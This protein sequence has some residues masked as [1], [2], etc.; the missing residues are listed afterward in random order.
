[1]IDYPVGD[2]YI[3]VEETQE[4]SYNV[5]FENWLAAAVS[6]ETPIQHETLEI[7]VVRGNGSAPDEVYIYDTITKQNYYMLVEDETTESI[8]IPHNLMF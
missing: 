7:L 6:M 8:C 2:G 4:C 5:T 1:M 3:Y